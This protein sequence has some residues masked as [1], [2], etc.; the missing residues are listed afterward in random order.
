MVIKMQDEIETK[1]KLY[2][3]IPKNIVRIIF[4]VIIFLML[5]IGISSFFITAYFEQ[6]PES[7][8]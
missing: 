3:K 6:R 1:E 5:F 7:A 4:V 2:Q 8:N